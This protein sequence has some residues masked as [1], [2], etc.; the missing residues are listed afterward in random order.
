MAG[1]RWPALRDRLLAADLEHSFHFSEY[2]GHGVELA[3]EA[4]HAGHRNFIAV[5]G[6]GTANEV[7]N[8]LLQTCGPDLDDIALGSVPWGTGN[9]WA[10]YWEFPA[11]AE[12][13]VELLRAG[14]CCRQDIGRVRLALPGG[15]RGYHYFLNCAGTGFDSYLLSE[16]NSARGS[17][18]RYFRYVLKC[19]LRFHASRLR[20]NID[21]AAAEDAVTLLEV[22]VGKYAG[23]GMRFAPSANADDGLF[24]VLLVGEMS[25]PR[26]LGSLNYLYNGNIKQHPAA[27]S[28]QC[29]ALSITARTAQYLQCDGELV[30]QL[31]V[32]IE[33]LPGALRVLARG[34]PAAG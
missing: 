34:S 31:P 6:D 22:C 28:W 4:L 3:R 26:L 15:T 12:E 13:C 24:E 16:M 30:G 23:A 20:V 21:G 25:I 18:V 33:I 27:R 14:R 29:R 10:R 11:T 2:R 32:D 5:G 9:D 17:R 7:L 8:G 1:R 19:L